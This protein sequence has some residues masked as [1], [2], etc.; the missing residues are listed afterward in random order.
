M[1]LTDDTVRGLRIAKVF[2][3]N[4]SRINSLSFYANGEAV[5]CASDDDTITIYDC[6]TGLPRRVLNSRKYGVDLIRWTHANNA[7]IHASTKLDDSIRYLSLHDH[8]YIRYFAGHTKKVTC[9]CM[10][11]ID[12]TFLSGSADKTLRL[13]DLRAPVAQGI[14]KLN[15]RP[16]AAFDP[17]GLI[18]ATGINSESVKLYDLR[19]YD[20]GPFSTFKLEREKD[21]DWTEM[22]FSPDGKLIL[23][24]TNG[25][26]IR[27]LDAFQG[28]PIHSFVGHTNAKGQ[29]LE[30]S[31]SPDAQFVFAGSTDGKVHC[32]QTETGARTI[33]TSERHT[34]AI[35]CCQFNPKYVHMVTTCQNVAFWLHEG[36][37]EGE[38]MME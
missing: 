21:C 22:K 28:Q 14:M 13:W 34:G 8:K 16:V 5:V 35:Y 31:F 23:I 29:S 18:F 10:S 1:H 11:P 2:R 19:S 12:D 9:L 4:E 20:K 30:A 25:S 26:V 27:L 32:W 7:A 24:S 37:G 17:E 3:A 36:E 33:L 6:M 15:S 38:D